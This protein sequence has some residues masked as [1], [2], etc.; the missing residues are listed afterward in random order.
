MNNA[1]KKLID[2]IK[3]YAD[4]ADT[5]YA[6]LDFVDGFIDHSAWYE[7]KKIEYGDKQKIGYKFKKPKFQ[8]LSLHRS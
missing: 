2:N 6:M 5:S 4:C 8:L 1:N 3:D 7:I